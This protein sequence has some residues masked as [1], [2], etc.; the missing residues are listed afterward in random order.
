MESTFAV[1]LNP[2]TPV[3]PLIT[4]TSSTSNGHPVPSG[5]SIVVEAPFVI[6]AIPIELTLPN[7]KVAEVFA[8]T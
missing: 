5:R 3:H 1:V 6:P 2:V 8:G 7:D 4:I